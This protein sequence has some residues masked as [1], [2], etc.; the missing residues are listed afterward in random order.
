LHVA[1]LIS[2]TVR[3]WKETIRWQIDP[4]ARESRL[5]TLLARLDSENWAFQDFHVF[6]NM[7][8]SK[9]FTIGLRDEWLEQGHRLNQLSEFCSMVKMVH[10][11]SVG[12][13]R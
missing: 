3:P 7:D 13:D 4:V 2:R 11:S 1:V 10:G 6:P 8:R 5:V 12:Q 9:R